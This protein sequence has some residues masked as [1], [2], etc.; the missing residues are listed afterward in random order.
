MDHAQTYT[1]SLKGEANGLAG[2]DLILAAQDRLLAGDIC[3]ALYDGDV[4]VARASKPAVLLSDIAACRFLF[5]VL[6]DSKDSK[7]RLQ[8]TYEAPTEKHGPALWCTSQ[9]E[10]C[11]RA[12]YRRYEWPGPP[13]L[14]PAPRLLSRRQQPPAAA[15]TYGFATRRN[16]LAACREIAGA[17]VTLGEAAAGIRCGRAGRDWTYNKRVCPMA[18]SA[19]LEVL[20]AVARV[21]AQ[22]VRAWPK[23]AQGSAPPLQSRRV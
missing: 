17:F 3:I 21:E 10:T 14:M 1:A 12:L 18:T 9:G 5:P 7:Y 6:P 4:C 15:W 8:V 11:V 19:Q 2:V 16:D 23:H 22:S 13:Q 20:A